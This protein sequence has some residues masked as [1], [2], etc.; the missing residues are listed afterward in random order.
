[1]VDRGGAKLSDLWLKEDYWA[2]WLGIFI[3]ILGLI[4]FLPQRPEGMQVKIEQANT[5]LKTE[6]ARAPFKTIAWYKAVDAK[7][8]L[9]ATG[10]SI[11]KKIKTFTSKPHGWKTNPIDSFYRSQAAADA[12]NAKAKPKYDAAKATSARG[13]AAARSRF[14]GTEGPNTADRRPA[15]ADARPHQRCSRRGR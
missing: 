9:K 11:G 2:I 6:S 14:A 4:I 1:M 3:L 10:S 15:I 5:T 8:K 13:V 7:M 12:A